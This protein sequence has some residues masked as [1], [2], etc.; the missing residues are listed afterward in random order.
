M[1]NWKGQYLNQSEWIS[2][3][4][5]DRHSHINPFD[6]LSVCFMLHLQSRSITIED[7]LNIYFM[8]AQ[9]LRS[10][11]GRFEIQVGLGNAYYNIYQIK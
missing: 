11:Q 4:I 7:I 5:A 10:S 1:E 9:Q 2:K 8:L 6:L 3:I